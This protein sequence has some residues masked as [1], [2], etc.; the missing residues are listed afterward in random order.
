MHYSLYINYYLLQHP[1]F[2]ISCSQYQCC[3]Y[4]EINYYLLQQLT[5]TVN[6]SKVSL[7]ET[8]T[9]SIV[10]PAGSF[11]LTCYTCTR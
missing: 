4:V 10:Y 3:A 7:T 1:T 2:T 9:Y 6:S 5:F 8:A 11:I